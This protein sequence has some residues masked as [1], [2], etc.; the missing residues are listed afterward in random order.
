[1]PGLLLNYFGQGALIL[2]DPEAVRAPFFL[3][4]PSW[5]LYPLI[6]LSTFATIIASQAVISG[7]FSVT[8]QA[9]QLG[10]LPRLVFR[11]TS[12]TEFGQIYM[13]NINWILM[14]CVVALVLGFQNSSH[15][16]HAYGI[17]VTGTMLV[18][19]IL[20]YTVARYHWGWSRLKALPP[21]LL[22]LVVDLAFFVA[23]STKIVA[24]GW[25]PLVVAL[26]VFILIQAW[27]EGRAEM[28]RYQEEASLSLESFLARLTANRAPRVAG[29][30]IF[31]SASPAS[32]PGALL[33]NL[34][35]NKVLHERVVLLT[36]LNEQV[37]VVPE[38]ERFTVNTYPH[39]FYRVLARY[40]FMESPDVPKILEACA[41]RGLTFNMMETSFF[42]GRETIIPTRRPDISMWR[43]KL[44][45]AMTRQAVSVTE[46]FRIPTN[47]V[48]E[49]GTQI[50]L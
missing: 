7:T 5:A 19:T 9:I 6:I 23:C 18:G 32:V 43:E 33:H 37:P 36:I 20:G 44:Y 40:G 8:H 27:R 10:F 35:H 4:A 25:V 12:A 49:L 21:F 15:L 34:K 39:A 41:A 30:A 28:T 11:H 38:A 3:L 17:A 24:G 45:I 1:M 13:P 50:E 22:F 46:F 16:A 29:T 47:R 48:V 42:L 31:M 14:T 26:L 2:D